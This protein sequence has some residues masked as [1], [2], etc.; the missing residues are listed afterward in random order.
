MTLFC[1]QCSQTEI[2]Q[3][4]SKPLSG[5]GKAE[6]KAVTAGCAA[7]HAQPCMVCSTATA[8]LHH[9]VNAQDYILHNSTAASLNSHMS[10]SVDKAE[11][12][13]LL[14]VCAE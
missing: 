10:Q 12:M 1:S 14:A 5:C 8:I 6:T 4:S 7:H 11:S 3:K 13:A 2:R 9:A